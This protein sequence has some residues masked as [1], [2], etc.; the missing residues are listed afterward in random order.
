MGSEG[1]GGAIS[2][3]GVPAELEPE[4]SV[5]GREAEDSREPNE[6]SDEDVAATAGDGLLPAVAGALCKEK[7]LK[8]MIRRA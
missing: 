2:V 7:N 1:G 3:S 5:S 4:E 8:E 6:V